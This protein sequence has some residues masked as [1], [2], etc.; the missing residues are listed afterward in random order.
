MRVTCAVRSW[1]QQGATKRKEKAP[2]GGVVQQ[3]AHIDKPQARRVPSESP[4][5]HSAP[6]STVQA[7]RNLG[8]GASEAARACEAA[9]ACSST[10]AS[11]A[12]LVAPQSPAPE[13]PAGQMAAPNGAAPNGAAP[14]A[15][16]PHTGAPNGTPAVAHRSNDASSP[17][18]G[19]T[20]RQQLSQLMGQAAAA[21]PSPVSGSANGAVHPA[22]EREEA[23]SVE[24]GAA[25][26]TAE[27]VAAG[28]LSEGAGG[29]GGADGRSGTP[30]MDKRWGALS[31]CEKDAAATLGYDERMWNEGIAPEACL[32]GWAELN[33]QQLYA[34]LQLGYT[35]ALWEAELADE[36]PVELTEDDVALPFADPR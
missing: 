31:L 18:A 25:A 14:N 7:P 11:D 16:A 29:G 8:L 32:C 20:A 1:W 30:G 26:P 10:S 23:Q 9:H 6:A 15:G 17:A 33:Q 36:D 4:N 2:P 21:P 34:A 35:E 3:A 5:S 28:A 24:G 22:A 12:V 13:S 27:A 19:P